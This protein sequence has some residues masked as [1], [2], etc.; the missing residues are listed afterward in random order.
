VIKKSKDHFKLMIDNLNYIRSL[1]KKKKK[2]IGVQK[3]QKGVK[4]MNFNN[5][6][7]VHPMNRSNNNPL[8]VT[9]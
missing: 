5:S 2:K 7:S 4:F 3:P 8:N 9:P 6:N 1:H